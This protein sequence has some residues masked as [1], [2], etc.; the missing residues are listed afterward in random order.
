MSGEDSD[1]VN[2]SVYVSPADSQVC[3]RVGTID[4]GCMDKRML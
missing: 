4:Y 3:S 1:P 2:S